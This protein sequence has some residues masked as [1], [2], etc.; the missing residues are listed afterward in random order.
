MT[1]PHL[2]LILAVLCA[3][4]AIR[5]RLWYFGVSAV[6]LAVTQSPQSPEY[7]RYV[8]LPWE[9]PRI[10]LCMAL[11]WKLISIATARVISGS[12]RYYTFSMGACIGGAMTCELI[13]L[14][15][16]NPKDWFEVVITARQ[17]VYFVIAVTSLVW[18]IRARITHPMPTRISA[19]ILLAIWSAW[20]WV[21]FLISANGIG[22]LWWLMTVRTD[23]NWGMST[24]YLTECQ[25]LI[26][27]A[28]IISFHRSHLS[29]KLRY[30]GVKVRA[31]LVD[32]DNSDVNTVQA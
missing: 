7:W 5:T 1:L 14:N 3:V 24:I 29:P 6:A 30:P 22:G 21:Q 32:V 11:T 10:V 26:A 23:S 20:L 27:I 2:R 28:L 18:G 9:I 17:C 12:E 25:I 19:D 31:P 16:H 15:W 13:Y 8:W 4:A